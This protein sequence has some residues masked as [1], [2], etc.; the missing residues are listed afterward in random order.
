[1]IHPYEIVAKS[2]LPAFRAMVS[3]RMTED[4]GMTQQEV[5]TRLGV[6][7]ASVSNYAR[8]AR[9]MMLDLEVDENIRKAAD[10][11]AAVL[12]SE[13][14]DHREALRMMT[15]VCDYVRFNHVLCGLHQDLEPGF[16]T[17]GCVACFGSLPPSS[18]TIK[19][20]APS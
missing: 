10:G 3:K 5:A 19:L 6:T 17:D 7:Q 2:A 18:G 8:K 13:K 1:M 9:G 12:A 4:Y 14:P 20:T 16:N 15:E 11:V